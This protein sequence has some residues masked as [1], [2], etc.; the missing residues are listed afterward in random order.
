MGK[1]LYA[2]FTNNKEK[3]NNREEDDPEVYA[4]DMNESK[5]QR[6]DL[7][8]FDNYQGTC[9][10]LIGKINTFLFTASTEN[11]FETLEV[12]CFIVKECKE[13]DYKYISIYN[14]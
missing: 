3:I 1:Y 11:N 13:C 8:D 12:L 6:L 7:G 5:R 9:K 4:M 10:K 14:F 2:Y